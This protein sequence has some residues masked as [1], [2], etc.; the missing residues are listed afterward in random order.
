MVREIMISV[1]DNKWSVYLKF[2]FFWES[3][4]LIKGI[5]KVIIKGNFFEV[6]SYLGLEGVRGEGEFI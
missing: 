6:N 3:L 1:E 2:I 4:V 5:I